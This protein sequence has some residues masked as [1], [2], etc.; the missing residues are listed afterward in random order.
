MYVLPIPLEITGDLCCRNLGG[1]F[2]LHYSPHGLYRD[3]LE[4]V[5]PCANRDAESAE[6][7]R[8]TPINPPF[9]SN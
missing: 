3:R 5:M 7:E 9:L 8:K 6:T 1:K 2:F 4:D